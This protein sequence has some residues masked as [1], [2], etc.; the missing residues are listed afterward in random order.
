MSVDGPPAY[1]CTFKGTREISW[2]TTAPELMRQLPS[3]L[4]HLVSSPPAAFFLKAHKNMC[5]P[6]A[7]SPACH[8]YEN[9]L[10]ISLTVTQHDRAAQKLQTNSVSYRD[11]CRFQCMEVVFVKGT[12][13]RTSKLFK[14]KLVSFRRMSR[15]KHQEFLSNSPKRLP[16]KEKPGIP[17]VWDTEVRIKKE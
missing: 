17:I 6:V 5:E 11:C 8:H 14:Y 7:L 2:E 15:S 3:S 12:L 4:F 9:G 10:R 13:Q 16:Y 1:P